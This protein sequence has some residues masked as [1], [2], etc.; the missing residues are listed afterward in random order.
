VTHICGE[1][2]KMLSG[3]NLVHVP[4]RGGPALVDL[5]GGQVQVMFVGISESIEYIKVGRL[6]ALAVTR[7][8]ENRAYKL[9]THPLF[10]WGSRMA[11]DGHGHAMTIADTARSAF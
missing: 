6:R 4:Y 11:V 10:G 2:F 5:L 3:V 9:A 7:R 8:N 1:L